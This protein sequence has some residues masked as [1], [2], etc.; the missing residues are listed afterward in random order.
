M[1]RQQRL[2][3]SYPD[4]YRASAV[5]LIE[6]SRRCIRIWSHDL[7][8][9]VYNK[10]AVQ[11]ALSAMVRSNRYAEARLLVADASTLVKSGH[12]LVALMRQLPSAIKIRQ[13]ASL[14]DRYR[15]NFI[16]ADLS[17]IAAGIEGEDDKAFVNFD[18]AVEAKDR[19][20]HFDYL[21][22]RGQENPELRALAL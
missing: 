4:E 9:A 17:A 3:V 7:E 19:V 2:Q 15:E 8:P 6:Q 13:C 21:W 12:C 22:E 11:Q 18:A 20:R 5:Q 1:D 14:P 10:P 16:V